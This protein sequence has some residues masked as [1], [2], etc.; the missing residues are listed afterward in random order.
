MFVRRNLPPQEQK[1]IQRIDR[2]LAKAKVVPQP[3][4]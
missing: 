2:A 1:L 3:S 4:P